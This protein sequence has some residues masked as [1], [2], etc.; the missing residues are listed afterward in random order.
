MVTSTVHYNLHVTIIR[1]IQNHIK[2]MINTVYKGL[3]LE[4]QF[5]SGAIQ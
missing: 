1:R 3:L 5:T 2:M 4:K